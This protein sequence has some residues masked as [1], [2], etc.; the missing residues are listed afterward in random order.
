[1]GCESATRR[2]VPPDQRL[3]PDELPR[4]EIDDRLVLEDELV[5]DDPPPKI[6]LELD[7]GVERGLHRR[8]KGDD[9]IM[10]PPTGQR[11][12]D[13]GVAAQDG[14]VDR[15]ITGLT[16]LTGRNADAGGELERPAAERHRL[17]PA[18][19]GPF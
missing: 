10:T 9:L 6:R 18:P 7:G 1:I 17:P 11:Q 14:R 5:P 3:G 12:G 4:S 19:R 15:L 13:M 8:D 16:G 2:V